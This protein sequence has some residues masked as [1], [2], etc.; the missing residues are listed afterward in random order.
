MEG[1]VGGH[2]LATQ[3]DVK[4]RSNLATDQSQLPKLDA[5]ADC[6]GRTQVTVAHMLPSLVNERNSYGNPLVEG[7]ETKHRVVARV[8]YT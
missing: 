8:V 7:H 5:A 4:R 1:K 6:M 3:K 2:S